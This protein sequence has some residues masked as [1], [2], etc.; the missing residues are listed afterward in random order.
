MKKIIT[1]FL[2][3]TA[4]SANAQI[5]FC[6]SGNHLKEPSYIMGSI[7]T[8]PDT[9]IEKMPAYLKAEAKCKQFYGEIDATDT[10]VTKTLTN[11]SLEIDTLPEG[12]NIMDLMTKD[13]I[14]LLNTRCKETIQVNFTDSTMIGL[15]NKYPASIAT[16]FDG[17][18]VLQESIK[19]YG[20]D[21]LGAKFTTKFDYTC[22]KRAKDRG[23]KVGQ[24]DETES[25]KSYVD[26]MM[27]TNY[28]KNMTIDSL[29]TFLN[30]L[31]EHRQFIANQIESIDRLLKYWY[32][33]DFDGLTIDDTFVKYVNN[34][35]VLFKDRNMKWLPIMQTAMNEVPTMFIFGV[36]HLIGDYGII[37][38]LRSKGY[39]V[40]QIKSN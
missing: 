3:L 29:V 7:H 10:L 9:V 4:M 32:N 34:L 33:G 23:L 28:Y 15:W 19:K 20:L 24:L 40:E 25:H 31:E 36:L 21:D 2:A 26:M 38:E 12:K 37:Q 14:E 30:N 16:F 8:I 22:L 13:Q 1:L 5:L 6:V 35:P 18:I 39:K 11:R 17:I 27:S